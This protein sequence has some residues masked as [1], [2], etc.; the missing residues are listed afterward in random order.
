MNG[1]PEHPTQATA[2]PEA[3]A[4]PASHELADTITTT[5]IEPSHPVSQ[6]WRLGA[7]VR[8]GEGVDYCVWCPEHATLELEILSQENETRR[9]TTQQDV[10]GYHH[11][12]DPDGIAGDRYSYVFPDGVARP[13]PASRGQE[14]DVR[15]Y[16]MVT[17]ASVFPW[18]DGE[19]QRPL[20]RD[21]VIYEIHVGTFTSEGTYLSA[22]SKLPHL[23]ELGITAIEIMPL[24]DFPGNR[25]WGY[26]GVLIYAPS[27]TYGRPDDLRAFVDAAHAQ[28]IA[29]IQ[30]VVYNHLG[31]DGNV[32]P[33][34]SRHYFNEACETPWGATL[35]FDGPG[36]FQVREYFVGNVEY[37]MHEFHMDGVRL[38]AAHWLLDKSAQHIITEIAHRVHEHGGYVIVE[39][40]RN[41][42]RLVEPAA[43]GGYG[44]DALWADDYHHIL[45]VGQTGEKHAYMRDFSGSLEETVET[46]KHG[47]LF[48]GQRAS[49]HGKGPRGTAIAH[50]PPQRLIHCI[51]NHDQTGN[52]AFGERIHA[53]IPHSSYRAISMMLCLTPYT[54]MIFMGQEWVCSTPFLY[55][56]DHNEELGRLVTAGRRREFGAFPEFND[57]ALLEDIPDPQLESTFYRSKLV[58]EER[59]LPP[60]DG[61]W[62]LYLECLNLRR[63]DTAFRPISRAEWSVDIY[64]S[65]VGYV[66]LDGVE[67]SYLLLF[68]LWP[69]SEPLEM[70]LENLPWREPTPRWE[71]VLSS[72]GERFGGTGTHLTS[73]DP[74][75]LFGQAE[76]LLLRSIH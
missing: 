74:S 63:A 7:T 65:G 59:T 21:L 44:C 6:V 49:V 1:E 29:V 18:T 39:D 36:S 68:H 45:R 60:H 57:P 67:H 19:W 54:P 4:R 58:W 53:V 42:S 41:E 76:T 61:I 5:E 35:N 70:N 26:D 73:A 55:F 43:Q 71:L 52:R 15:G 22:I 32:L 10:N 28:G 51:S 12:H 25:N 13:D 24:A 3:V 27:R 16:S 38:D 48:R 56:T 11:A 37:W 72:N 20:F 75:Y 40:E 34:F 23:K 33:A 8:A 2:A 69:G 46:L 64:Q 31:P 17:D 66:R 50:V 14:A 62:Q 47:W 9:L 30:D